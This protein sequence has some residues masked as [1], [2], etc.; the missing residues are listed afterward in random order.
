MFSPVFSR[1]FSL[2]TLFLALVPNTS[3]F[4]DPGKSLSPTDVAAIRALLERYRMGWLAGNPDTVRR[5]FTQDA[6]LLPHHGV[7]PVV[8]MAA[9]N[10][11]WFPASSAKTT[12]TKFVQM[13]DEVGGEGTLAYVRGRSEVAWRVDDG[14]NSQNWRNGGN[15]L[16]VLKKQSD[17]KW[18][19]SHLIWDDPPNQQVN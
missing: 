13:L 15:F 7:L 18:L 14:A 9:I 5:C 1:M 2:A 6:V 8:G 3:A 16:A 4:A 19:M 17:G 10:E 11:F 12:I